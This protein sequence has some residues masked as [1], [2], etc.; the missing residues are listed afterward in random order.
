MSKPSKVGLTSTQ[1]PPGISP[2]TVIRTMPGFRDPSRRSTQ[3][4][5]VEVR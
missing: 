2:G 5:G 4:R 3:R 1:A